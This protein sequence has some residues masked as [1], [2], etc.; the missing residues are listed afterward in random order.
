MMF[1][2]EKDKVEGL[3]KEQL[4][5]KKQEEEIKRGN[6]EWLTTESLWE[7]KRHQTEEK[8]DAAKKEKEM[9]TKKFRNKII[10]E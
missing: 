9:K 7:Q 5:K 10:Q 3:Q 8:V 2:M 6:T 1:V 4:K